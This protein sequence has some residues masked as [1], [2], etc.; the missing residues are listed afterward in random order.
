[1]EGYPQLVKE[2]DIVLTELPSLKLVWAHACGRS[3]SQVINTLLQKHPNLYC[4]LSNMTN[5]GGYGSG[6]PRAEDFT[7]KIEVNGIFDDEFKN[8]IIQY[9]NRFFVGM[10]VAHQSRWTMEKGNTFERRVQRT[11]DL[12]GTLPLTIAKKLAYENVIQVYKLPT[13]ESILKN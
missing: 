4:D 3:N 7:K 6:W 10:D 5:T 13:I 9:P 2:L 1:M 8:L 11:R 12:L